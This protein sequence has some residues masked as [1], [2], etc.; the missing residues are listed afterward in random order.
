M[1][2]VSEHVL[3]SGARGKSD[4]W[5]QARIFGSL[6][7]D[8][9]ATGVTANLAAVVAAVDGAGAIACHADAALAAHRSVI[10]VMCESL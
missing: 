1:G 5:M 8:V 3:A 7:S 9:L 2:V 6:T 10:Q 4:S